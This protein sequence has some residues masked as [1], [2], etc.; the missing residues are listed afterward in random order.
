MFMEKQGWLAEGVDIDPVSVDQARAKGLQVR[1]GSLEAQSYPDN[2]FDAVTMSHLI[3]HVYDPLAVFQEC[4]RILK[5][6][7]RLVVVTPNNESWGHKIYKT[8]WL[9]LDPPRHLHIFSLMSLNSLTKKAGFQKFKSSTTIREANG[10]FVASRAIHSTGKYLWG[11]SI[12]YPVRIW[13][14][15]MQL[16]EWAILKLK[17]GLGEDIVMVGE[18]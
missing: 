13:A 10:L 12:T 9:A 3:E 6:G 4:H 15:G 14:R 5:P 2:Y 17:P 1:S 16:A 11:S 8:S 7:G 18:K